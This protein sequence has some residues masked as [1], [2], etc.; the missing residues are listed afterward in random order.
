VTHDPGIAARCDRQLKIEAGRL[1]T[2]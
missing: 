1:V 2:G